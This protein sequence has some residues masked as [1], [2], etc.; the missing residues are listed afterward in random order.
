MR[1]PETLVNATF[2]KYFEKMNRLEASLDRADLRLCAL[3][4]PAVG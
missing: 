4:V 3:I 1:A 2:P